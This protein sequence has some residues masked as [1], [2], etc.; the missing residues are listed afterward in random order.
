[1]SS[2]KKITHPHRN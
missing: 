2:E 1:M